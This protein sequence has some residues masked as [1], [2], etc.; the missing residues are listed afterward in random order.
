MNEQNAGGAAGKGLI[1]KFLA[2]AAPYWRS[3]EKGMAWALLLTISALNIAMV[4]CNVL[5][6]QWNA[7]F[8]NALQQRDWGRFL[9]LLQ[10]FAALAFGFIGCAVL[11]SYLT[12]MLNLRWRR[13]LTDFYLRQWLDGRAYCLLELKSYGTDNPD[14]RIAEDLKALTATSLN[15]GF[16]LIRNLATLACFVG[17]LWQLSGPLSLARIGWNVS[18]PGY[19]VWVSLAYA[20]L[21][22]GLMHALGRRLSRINMEGERR[23]ADFRYAAVRLRE[24]AQEV[25]LSGGED[26]ERS[27]LN[28]RFQAICANWRLLIA[29]EWRLNGARAGYAQLAVI[30][31]M[32]VC[33][34]GYF[35]GK[36][37]LGGLMQAISAFA[38]VQGALSWMVNAYEILASWKA[39]IERLSSFQR[40][41]QQARQ[42]LAH[43]RIS[44]RPG[45]EIRLSAV[46]VSLPGGQALLQGIHLQASAGE[47]IV[48]KGASGS[49]KSALLKALAGIWPWGK[50][51][52]TLPPNKVMFLPQRPYLPIGTLREAISYPAASN[53][54]TTVQQTFVLSQCQLGHLTPQLDENCNWSARLS[55]GEQQRL[56]LARAL[57]HRPQWLLLDDAT[58][59]LDVPNQRHCYALLRTELP[60]S[61][62]ISVSHR[63][64]VDAC[65]DRIWQIG[66]YSLGPSI[67]AAIL[68]R[69]RGQAADGAVSIR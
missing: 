61:T 30:F 5:L 4:Y 55:A 62:I 58:S 57:L 10:V 40:A 63:P 54:F 6:N 28:R 11:M 49:G 24:H 35:A 45:D 44:R 68:S 20:L 37:A 69:S 1:A 41:A 8:F 38:Q 48:L 64:E 27:A 53:A 47:R 32:L 15:L 42:E 52:I 18:L 34:P 36:F 67:D 12:S 43:S 2:L 59:A 29:A 13:W 60:H 16:E 50:G 51:S 66:D 26:V 65:H 21:G 3:E 23:E 56:A 7:D 22:S 14:Q 46:D 9:Q 33:A 31:P 25:A 39:N 17:I 19:L